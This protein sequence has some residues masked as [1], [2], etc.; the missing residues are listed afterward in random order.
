M[1]RADLPFMPEFYD[2]YINLVEDLPL[3]EA[4]QHYN[5]DWLAQEK[6]KLIALGEKVYAPGKWS[7]R[8]I[9]QHLIDTERIMNYRALRFARND[10][11]EL[12]GMGQ[13][14]F[15]EQ[16][17]AGRRGVDELLEEFKLVRLS[18]IALFRSFTDEMMRR[19]GICFQ[20]KTNVLALGFTMIGHPI[21]HVNIL[22]ERYYPLIS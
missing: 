13:D 19:E 9:L 8:D 6:D 16:A 20:K 21:H 18:T 2:R 12:H 14:N 17:Q 5:A 4:L 22:K 1:Q 15:A 3:L 10:K 7:A 11:K